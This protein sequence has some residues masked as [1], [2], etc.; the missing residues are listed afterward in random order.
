MTCNFTRLF[1]GLL[2]LT[3]WT[4]C[5][6]HIYVP[7][8]VNTPL[9]KEKHEFKGSISPHNLQAAFALSD[10]IAIMANGQYVYRFDWN[11]RQDNDDDIFIDQ[12]VR[13]GLV[14][15]AVGY[16]TPMDQRKRMIFEVFGGYGNGRFK[17]QAQK[18]SDNTTYQPDDLQ[19]SSHFSKVFVQPGIGF[20]HP[21]FEAGF[22]SRFSL[23][24]FY[25]MRTGPRAFENRPN[26]KERFLR[27]SHQP[28]VAF[29]PAFTCRVGY[30]YA[31]FQLQL[32][33]CT[34]INEE[35]YPSSYSNN[36]YFQPVNLNAGVSV[37][38]G[39]WYDDFRKK[40]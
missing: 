20:V 10:H 40:K 2:A 15:G 19:L 16:F 34:L 5:D 24:N 38:I 29:E 26:D 23:L 32:L 35:D 4:S 31:K 1:A 9:L 18:F 33:F 14:E 22:S 39:H 6:R 36:N 25:N 30:K 28:L 17:T 21:I 3:V 7:N 8:T 37:N 12:H 11:E 27:I 13:G